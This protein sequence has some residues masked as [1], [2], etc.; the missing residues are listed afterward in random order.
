M[1][2]GIG[3]STLVQALSSIIPSTTTTFEPTEVFTKEGDTCIVDTCGYGALLRVCKY[4]NVIIFIYTFLSGRGYI[5][6][7]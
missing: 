4:K 3:K 1:Y 5:L 2:K 6:Q 7:C